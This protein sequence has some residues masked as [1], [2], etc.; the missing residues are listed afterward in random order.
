MA[1]PPSATSTPISSDPVTHFSG[2]SRTLFVG[3]VHGC[4]DELKLLL[5]ETAPSRVILIGDMF[6]KGQKPLGVWKLIKKWKIEAVFG[7]HEA[8]L[9]QEYRA[10]KHQK[11]PKKMIEWVKTLPLWIEEE[12]FLA[13]HAGVNPFFPEQTL[14][15][16]AIVVRRWP[17]DSDLQNPFWWQLYQGKKLIIYG[18]DAPRK[19][20]DYRPRTL[21]LDTGCVYGGYLTGYLLEED[22][23]VQVKAKQAYC[24]IQHKNI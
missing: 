5:K 20:Q 7:N 10:G 2:K 3:D 14:R 11:Y 8:K 1:T 23:L 17:D 24:S 16:T 12:G 9:L 15:T 6:T 19:L 13:V 4:A 21:G 22:R 18:H